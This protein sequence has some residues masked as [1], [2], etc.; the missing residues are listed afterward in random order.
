MMVL[1]NKKRWP[2]I[3]STSN[4][5]SRNYCTR[6]THNWQEENFTT[7]NGFTVEYPSSFWNPVNSPVDSLVMQTQK[8]GYGFGHDGRIRDTDTDNFGVDPF[9]FLSDI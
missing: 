3:K 6:Q 4:T 1:Q 2:L 8:Q 5:I 7:S 9:G